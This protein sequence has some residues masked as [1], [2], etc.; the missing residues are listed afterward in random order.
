[1]K[2]IISPRWQGATFRRGIR[3]K[4]G[5]LTKILEFGKDE[6]GNAIAVDVADKDL[7]YV[8]NDIGNALDVAGDKDKPDAAATHDAVM[9]VVLA[10][11]ELAA[12]EKREPEF[13]TRQLEAIAAEADK[14]GETPP[15][16]APAPKA[17]PPK[18]EE[19]KA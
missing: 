3:D 11:K 7:P 4:K 1:M 18:K 17:A 14:A 10:E 15:P 5:K 2:L 13:T 6:H 16:P 9:A 12:K 8:A 19:T